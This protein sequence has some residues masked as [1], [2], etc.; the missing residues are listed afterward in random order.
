M[1]STIFVLIETTKSR[2]T[3]NCCYRTRHLFLRS[4]SLNSPAIYRLCP[5]LVAAITR[6]FIRRTIGEIQNQTDLHVV[7]ARYVQR[8]VE[9]STQGFSYSGIENLPE[10]QAVLFVSN[11]RD[12][13]L[14]SILVNYALWLNKLPP[15]QIAVGENL[16]THGFETEFMRLNGSFFG[17]TLCRKLSPTLRCTK[18]DFTVHP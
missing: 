6:S 11:H 5:P 4:A 16:F 18:Q 8:I 1:N 7:L 17:Q 15:V 10:N 12:I 9:T 13:T 3:L 2:N 14:D